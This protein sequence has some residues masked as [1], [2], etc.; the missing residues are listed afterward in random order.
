MMNFTL[1]V[2]P[3]INSTLEVDSAECYVSG[4]RFGE[5]AGASL[6]PLKGSVR[7]DINH[8]DI[9]NFYGGGVNANKPVEGNIRTDIANSH[10]ERFCGGPKFGDMSL[11]KTVT[12]NATNCTFGT[13]FGAG[14]GGNSYNRVKY[15]DQSDKRPS[16]FQSYYSD[17]TTANDGKDRG[18]YFDGVTT[19]TSTTNF[20]YGLLVRQVPVFL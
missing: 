8:A 17:G 12:T 16:E 19:K 13:F 10:V 4:G 6:E 7:W 3:D 9:T 11:G 2:Q 5:M 18:K 14:F 15:T 1:P 20:L